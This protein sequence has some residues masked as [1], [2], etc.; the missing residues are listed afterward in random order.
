MS[1]QNKRIRQGT[2]SRALKQRPVTFRCHWCDK[3]VTELRYPGPTPNYG[4]A[5]KAEATRYVEAVKKARQ[6]GAP[7]PQRRRTT[8]CWNSPTNL[9]THGYIDPA[10]HDDDDKLQRIQAALE[11]RHIDRADENVRRF[12]DECG[13]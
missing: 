7:T 10:A 9:L 11:A 13:L 4:L 5:C 6:R 2:R 8:T 1:H 12:L 3:L